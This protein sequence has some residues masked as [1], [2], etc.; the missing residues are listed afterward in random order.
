MK[1][2]FL[3]LAFLAGT[4]L[5]AKAQ[6][7]EASIERIEI[8]YQGKTVKARCLRV[9]SE[10]PMPAG[11]VW[12][13]VQTPALLQFV[14]KGMI[15]FKPEGGG[16]PPKWEAGETYGTKMR[17]WGFIPFGGTH[18]LSVERIEQ[19]SFTISTHEWDR[20]AKVWKHEITLQDLG[21]GRTRYEDRIIIYGGRLT[22]LITAFAKRFYIHRQR[23]WQ[24][25]A[26]R[27]M[28]FTKQ[29]G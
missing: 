7:P 8:E 14:A 28:D 16:F 26:E 1:P 5:H 29:S 25:V 22:G 20:R 13:N 12:A 24:L 2:L 23:R 19:D 21:E 6:R 27:R 9:Q 3:G 17:L 10:I 4:A 11:Q 15:R 18:H